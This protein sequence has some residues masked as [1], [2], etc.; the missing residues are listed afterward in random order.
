MTRKTHPVDY[1]VD[2]QSRAVSRVLYPMPQ[3]ASRGKLARALVAAR[4]V[5]CPG[6][7][8][9]GFNDMRSSVAATSVS[10]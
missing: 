7:V 10:S 3:V 5:V 6:E 2:V 8:V 4:R 1:G 9:V